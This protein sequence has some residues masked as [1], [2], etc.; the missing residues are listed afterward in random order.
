[1]G[2]KAILTLQ[3]CLLFITTALLKTTD[4]LKKTSAESSTETTLNLLLTLLNYLWGF[5]VYLFMFICVSLV[6]WLSCSCARRV[7]CYSTNIITLSKRPFCTTETAQVW[8]TCPCVANRRN[9]N[10]SGLIVLCKSHNF[11]LHLQK[12][13]AEAHI[14]DEK[15]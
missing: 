2:I 15:F 6:L 5:S 1:M 4:W 9:W 14:A 12:Q 7:S 13:S 8:K 3:G 11:C 10:G